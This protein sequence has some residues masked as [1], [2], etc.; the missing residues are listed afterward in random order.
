MEGT[1]VHND[2]ATNF[3]DLIPIRTPPR[4]GPPM[5]FLPPK[6]GKANTLNVTEEWG[7]SHILPAIEDSGRWENIPICKPSLMTYPDNGAELSDQE[8]QENDKKMAELARTGEKKHKLISC[9]WTSA[10]FYTR[11]ERTFVDD[12]RQRLLQ[13]LEFNKLAGVDHVYIFD[14]SG[15]V[16]GNK[17]LKPITDQFPGFATRIDWPAKVCNNRPGNQDNKGERST[18]YAAESACRLR[19]GAHSDWL[20][21]HDTDE[22]LTPL[23]PNNSLKDVLNKVEKEDIRI[24]NFYSKR[25][26]LQVKY[27]NTTG[28]EKSTFNPALPP[29]KSFLQVYNCNIEK[30]PRKKLMPAEKAIY[31]PDYVHMHFVHYSTVTSDNKMS[32]QEAKAINHA[33]RRVYKEAHIR[34]VDEETEATMLHT[35][36]IVEKETRQWDRS[37]DTN[38]GVAYPPGTSEK[39]GTVTVEINGNTLPA[40]CY[41]VEKIDQYWAPKLEAAMK[42][43]AGMLTKPK[44]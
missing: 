33:W 31:R 25:S 41:P 9:T 19:F 21:A 37:P 29:D 30:P 39:N 28:A 15:A 1:S 34:Y 38:V 35:K 13:W 12:G 42:D 40:N 44:T 14:N 3:V 36:A 4:Y 22:Y 20:A 16:D 6:Y 27:F 17:T 43:R 7:D 24:L 5:E 2:Y 23:G 11:G 32:E 18:Q 8:I 10:G 26:K